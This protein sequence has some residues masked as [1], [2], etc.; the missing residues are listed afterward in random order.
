MQTKRL[1][2][3]YYWLLYCLW[4]NLFESPAQSKL[5]VEWEK[6]H[7][8]R[9]NEKNVTA[10]AATRDGGC[11]MVGYSSSDDQFFPLS[12]GTLNTI[13]LK[14]DA[15][16][17]LLWYQKPY[18]RP[19]SREV[20][21]QAVE[22]IAGNIYL[23][24]ALWDP[25]MIDGAWL[26]KMDASGNVIW[27]K[28]YDT[29][30][31]ASFKDID[32][33]SDGRIWASGSIVSVN[34]GSVDLWLVEVDT[35]GTVLRSYIYGNAQHEE[36]ASTELLPG[37]GFLLTGIR[38]VSPTLTPGQWSVTNFDDADNFVIL[39]D[40]DGGLVDSLLLRDSLIE[41]ACS[42]MFPTEDGYIGTGYYEAAKPP[43]SYFYAVKYDKNW[44]KIREIR[45]GGGEDDYG[46]AVQTTAGNI[47]I[48]GRTGSEDI[49]DPPIGLGDAW[50]VC[51]DAHLRQLWT[52]RY[53]IERKF[54]NS[55]CLAPAADSSGYFLAGDISQN[56]NS[57]F[58][59]FWLAKF[60]E[61]PTHSSNPCYDFS[62]SPNPL[63]G[64]GLL[65]VE[66]RYGL[67]E[68]VNWQLFGST[69]Q[70]LGSGLFRPGTYV[71]T[72][73]SETL[74]DGLYWL[75]LFCPEGAVVKPV[76]KMGE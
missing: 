5:T 50:L 42:D 30:G 27:S 61:K 74:P 46:G 4:A 49:S 55:R 22:D 51:L 45:I 39:T 21:H 9:Q 17:R 32:F 67:N 75:R 37:G 34:G 64:D 18:N 25:G 1:Q 53:G 7:G 70:I 71:Y 29:F 35:E 60:V 19:G 31:Y 13:V 15:M 44:N 73:L 2:L 58:G 12:K 38:D 56:T 48:L 59:D 68:D 54:L 57:E 52:T 3:N 8:G 10:L 72:P 6:I 26:L 43:W 36:L 33:S 69:G 62:I 28:T 40:Q 76:I 23:A 16:G 20:F 11:V 41:E 24:G 63:S 65:K 14:F 66:L 47:L